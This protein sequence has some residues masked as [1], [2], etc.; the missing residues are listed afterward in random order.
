LL[1]YKILDKKLKNM[2]RTTF[3]SILCM[4]LTTIAS[5]Q[6]TQLGSDIDG[7]AAGDY[8]SK[9]ISFSSDGN[10]V[11]I[12]A[13]HNSGNGADAG[14]VR[15]YQILLGIWTQVGA[16]IDGETAGDLSGTSV[17]LSSDGNTVAIG[18]TGND[19]NGASAGHVR[20]YHFSGTAWTQVGVM[21]HMALL[22]KAK[23]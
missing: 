16:D 11:A 12:G 7:E 2:T 10:T 4:L 6:W 9:S 18:A 14:Q 3:L 19:G 1:F 23:L 15:I 20:I 17:S 21:Y 13:H 5:A 8:F 22:H